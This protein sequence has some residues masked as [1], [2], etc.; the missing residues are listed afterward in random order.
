MLRYFLTAATAVL[1]VSLVPGC[2]SKD[3]L[4]TVGDQTITRDEFLTVF[5][6]L[7]AEEQVG[8]LEPSGRM[9]LME[10]IVR[11]KLLLLAWEEDQTVSRGYED[12]YRIAFLSDSMYQRIAME[13]DPQLYLDS[14]TNCGYASFTIRTVLLDDSAE[15]FSLAEE[16]NQ[17]H[18]EITLQSL[19]AP[20]SDRSGT[21][22]RTLSG[23]VHRI[24]PN[25]LPLISMETGEAHV[26]PMYGEWCVAMLELTEGEWIQ[27]ESA[28]VAGFMNLLNSSAKD[29]ILYTGIASLAD[30]CLLSGTFLAP[31]GEG[32]ETPVVLMNS[33]TL[34]VK[35]ILSGMRMASPEN[36]FGGVP[37]ELEMFSP[38]ELF[39]SPEVTLWFHVKALAQRNSLSILAAEEGI[40]LG[41]GVLD[42]SRAESVVRE[43]V[44]RNV[45][46]D[47]AAV[48]QWYQ[49]NSSMFILPERRSVLLGYTD[50]LSAA[51]LSI[52]P[53]DISSIDGLQTVT[54]NSGAMIPTPLQV[55]ESFGPILGQ[56]IFSADTGVLTGPVYLEGEL[57]G[58]FE[59]VEVRPPGVADLEEI[60]PLA[61]ATAAEAMFEQGFESLMEEL[62]RTYPVKI[63]TAEVSNI[64]LWGSVQ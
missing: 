53:S 38:P 14:L 43:R 49:E 62:K 13:Y 10:R 2:G 9:E 20:W 54:D 61:A 26:L 8:V 16:W 28:A 31:S 35:D 64:D 36:F 37:E 27:D 5:N 59:V 23:P 55:Q 17:G 12:L 22:Y 57:A 46:P 7:P 3:Q 32:D 44:L 33:D 21:S 40:V 25:F 48:A 58:W 52:V 51:G 29:T 1:I 39:I 42:Y 50:S 63:D 19:T 30:N 34:T 11:K 60:Y 4:G 6:A 56:E 41:E 18:F 15:A 24:T 45:I 47:S